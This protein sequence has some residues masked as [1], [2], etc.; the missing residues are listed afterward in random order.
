M[1][2]HELKEQLVKKIVQPLYIFTGEEV[3]IMDLYL[4]KISKVSGLP[5]K[6]VDSIES[7]FNKMQN[8]NSFVN[9]AYCYIIRDDKDY[10]AQEKV[11]DRFNTG[12]AQSNNIIILIYTNLD[13]RGKFYKHHNSPNSADLPFADK[14]YIIEFEKL[15]PEVLAKYIKKDIG[16]DIPM[17][18]E[19][20]GICDCNYNRIKLECDKLQHLAVVRGCKIAQAY[21][22]ALEENILYIQPGA[23]LF[24]F[25][26]AVCM[27]DIDR[28]Y[29]L[30]Q[31][32]KANNENP[33]AMISLIYSNLKSI[34]LVTSAGNGQG[35]T[36]KTGLT[37]WQVKLAKEKGNHYSIGEL[38]SAIT[39]LRTTEKGIKTGMIEQEMAIDYILVNI[40]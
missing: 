37:A 26:D 12:A 28:V 10:L 16:L 13:K 14:S 17:G 22:I 2:L 20:A 33:L 25:I 5:M 36:E 34:L 38:V 3:A 35:I 39:I 23:V 29:N 21:E 19:L 4:D 31:Q 40:L 11:W 24:E 6:R 7:I 15:I 18:I 30:L 8:T 27:R 32:L 9:Q 1:Q